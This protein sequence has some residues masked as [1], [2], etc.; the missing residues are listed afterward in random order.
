M[1]AAPAETPATAPEATPV[2]YNWETQNASDLLTEDELNTGLLHLPVSLL[3]HS[4][5]MTG[6]FAKPYGEAQGQPEP[7]GCPF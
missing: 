2:A 3:V 1:V 7:S 4:R 5:L 6:I